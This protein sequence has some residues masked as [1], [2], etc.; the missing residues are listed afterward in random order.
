MK[1]WNDRALRYLF[2]GIIALIILLSY[3]IIKDF[4]IAIVSAFILSY[5][6]KPL[7]DKLAKYVGKVAAAMI[8]LAGV[9]LTTLFIIGLIITSLISEVSILL[10][11]NLVQSFLDKVN[12][13][14]YNET[15]NKYISEIIKQSGR[16]IIN[17]ISST[18]TEIPK[19]VISL[20]VIFFVS[21][22]LLVEWDN[23]KRRVAEI[24]PFKNRKEIINNVELITKDILIGTFL[25][26]IIE[27]I[28]AI[29]GF[30]ILGIKFAFLLG[31][32]IGMFAFI[33]ALGPMLV[34]APV[35]I[36]KFVQGEMMIALGVVM[37]GIVLSVLIDSLL[38]I[39]LVGKRSK[40]HPVIMLLGIFGGIPLFGP[41]GFIL[42]PMILAILLTIINNIPKIE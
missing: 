14:P 1:S 23:L 35:A 29:I 13:L 22:Y 20:F 10:S 11:Q 16:L 4:L 26:A 18:I 40:I 31:I 36:I 39:K 34:W 17:S 41:I 3:L 6:L 33:P 24:L 42:G 9:I 28:I 38:R 8:V 12:N 30:W 25:I 15:L 7:N 5:L 32:I 37:I 27:T 21:Y 19:R 2:W